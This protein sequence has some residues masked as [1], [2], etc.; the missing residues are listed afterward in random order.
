MHHHLPDPPR[1]S[2]A[3]EIGQA[4]P[5]CDIFDSYDFTAIHAVTL[6]ADLEHS[7]MMS[8]AFDLRDYDQL[9]NVFQE[10]M[11]H[12]IVMLKAQRMDVAEANVVG[13]QCSI[14]F[15]DP[16]EV[17]DNYC[18]EGPHAAEGPTRDALLSKCQRRNQEL[19][20]GALKAAIQLKN[21]WLTHP[22][23]IERIRQ[24]REALTLG[25]GLNVG[26]VHYRSRADG[27]RRI[28]GHAVNVGK[29]IETASR[30][31]R[32]SRIMLGQKAR[33]LLRS[34]IVRHSQ[35]RQ[36]V[37]FASHEISLDLLKGVI[38]RHPVYELKFY[39][40]LNV[41]TSETVYE[42]YERILNKDRTNVWAYY[43][44]FDHYAYQ[45]GDW[46][47]AYELV[48]QT[49]LV[50]PHDEKVL[51]DLSKCLLRLGHLEQAKRIAEQAL[52]LNPDFDLVYEELAVIA[53]LQGDAAGQILHM[54]D[55][56]RLSPD[57]PSN[58]RNLGLALCSHGCIDEGAYY[59][60]Q[61]L[62]RYPDYITHAGFQESVT[63]A[64]AGKPIPQLLQALLK[65]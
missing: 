65:A 64:C 43:L 47:R 6:F 36:R 46:G 25:V 24:H 26:L 21:I 15:Y 13:D 61:A 31:G 30:E 16:T 7:V 29:R 37:F 35:L 5:P 53:D 19:M 38:Q 11:Q 1:Q 52:S 20:Y 57:S 23:N 42:Q 56:L 49:Q 28:E 32:Y 18:L 14:F 22:I 48:K 55:A 33:D 58:N 9:I 51:L 34:H 50:Y 54:R 44:L 2:S 8:S 62:M 63:D 12:L 17:V 39:H 60:V 27:E 40:R 45:R 59:L 10:T 4:Q 41:P 3:D